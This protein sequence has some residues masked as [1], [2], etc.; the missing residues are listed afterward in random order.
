[1]RFF[2]NLL[3]YVGF[4][5][6]LL[7]GVWHVLPCCFFVFVAIVGGAVCVLAWIGRGSIRF[8]DKLYMK[9]LG[10]KNLW[11]FLLVPVLLFVALVLHWHAGGLGDWRNVSMLIALISSS[12][13]AIGHYVH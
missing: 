13:F 7:L 11:Q 5:L 9:T 6:C 2:F 12:F 10:R 8:Y 1:M 3:A 4:V